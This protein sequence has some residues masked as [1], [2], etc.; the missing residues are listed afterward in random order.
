LDGHLD[1]EQI[2]DA[3]LPARSGSAF[4]G[5]AGHGGNSMTPQ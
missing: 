1:A 4:S 3:D 2:P 5:G